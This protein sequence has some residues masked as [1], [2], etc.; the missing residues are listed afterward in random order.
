MG[1][2]ESMVTVNNSQNDSAEC[3]V[4]VDVLSAIIDLLRLKLFI[5]VPVKMLIDIAY[6]NDNRTNDPCT[7]NSALIHVISVCTI[8]NSLQ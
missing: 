4:G 5:A 1:R 3:G 2:T 7:I 8:T 6:V